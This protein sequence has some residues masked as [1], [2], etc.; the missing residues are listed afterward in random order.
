MD[1]QDLPIWVFI[2]VGFAAQMIDGALG[3]AYG[4]TSTT[5]LEQ[6]GRASEIRQRIRAHGRSG[7]DGDLR[8]VALARWATYIST[9]PSG[10]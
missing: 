8:A 10:W 1:I 3:M 4:V 7:D 2:L 5:I 6:P 9:W